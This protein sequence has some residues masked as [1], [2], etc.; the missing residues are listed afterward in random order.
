MHVGSLLTCT[1]AGTLSLPVLSAG[2]A[3]LTHLVRSCDRSLRPKDWPLGSMWMHGS[4][5]LPAGDQLEYCQRQRQYC[6]ECNCSP[7]D[8]WWCCCCSC[9]NK[10]LGDGID[11]G[12]QQYDCLGEL[13]SDT[14]AL[15]EQ[16]GGEDA[17]INIKYMV[18]HKSSAYNPGWFSAPD[19]C[20]L[21]C[22]LQ[23][24]AP[25]SLLYSLLGMLSAERWYT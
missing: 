15:L 25:S 16:R 18:G 22:Q 3:C 23:W 7:A 11:Y 2:F 14:L 12:Q 10:N 17:F 24:S 1:R 5:V 6:T 13:I 8:P 9:R 19:Q 4:M 20:A 21:P